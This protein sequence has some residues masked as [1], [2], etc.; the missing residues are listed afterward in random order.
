MARNWRRWPPFFKAPFLEL[1]K[2]LKSS[3]QALALNEAAFRLRALGRLRDA[4]D[5]LRKGAEL[6][7]QG[8]DLKNAAAGYGNL[9]EL[10][11]VLGELDS[12]VFD[13][14]EG[15]LEPGRWRSAMPAG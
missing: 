10:L 14:N 13:G 1:S 11:L 7:V 6:T 9:A 5:P 8:E 3:D 4:V 15:A 12:P 2:R